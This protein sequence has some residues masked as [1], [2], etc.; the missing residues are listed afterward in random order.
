MLA[1][2]ALV[3]LVVGACAPQRTTFAA[4][5]TATPAFDRAA[6]DAKALEI[7]DRVIAAAGGIDRWN[8]AR[9]IRWSES[10]TTDPGKPPISF[11]EAWD[12]WNGRH[13][14]RLRAAGGDAIVMRDLYGARQTAFG[15]VGHQRQGLSGPDSE[16]LFASARERWELD[17]TLL[18]LPFLLEASGNKLALT[19]EF[20]GEN[21]QPPLDDLK[22]TFDPKDPSRTAT[23]H[24][25][26]NRTSNQIERIEIIK[27]GDPDNQ[28]LG[29]KPGAW[30]DV[31][32]MKLATTYQNIGMP[33]EVITYTAIKVSAE[34]DD[35][36]YVPVTQ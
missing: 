3:G 25:M 21:G 31:G 27:A 32:G 5:P 28:R 1:R 4:H 30:T 29:Y 7:A 33:S 6:S 34:P 17:T 12:R 20:P 10:V 26:V 2:I 18:F 22:L 36:L 9:Q 23:Y 16:H 19:G 8:A 13:Y 14:Y 35:E 24:A 11:D 15:E